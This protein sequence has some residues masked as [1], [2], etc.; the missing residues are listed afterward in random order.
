MKLGAPAAAGDKT[1]TLAEPVTGWK[2]GDH[3]FLTSAKEQDLVLIC[4]STS[5]KVLWEKL[6]GSGDQPVRGDEGNMASPSP[7]TDGKLVVCGT[8]APAGTQTYSFIVARLKAD[9]TPDINFGSN[10]VVTTS[11]T[12][13]PDPPAVALSYLTLSPPRMAIQND[14]NTVISGTVWRNISTTTAPT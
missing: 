3:I 4:V 10:G 2:P 14:G 6:L 11:V 9:G 7:V 8:R 1:V 5:G 13:V 12:P